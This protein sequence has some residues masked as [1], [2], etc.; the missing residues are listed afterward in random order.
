MNPLIPPISY[1]RILKISS[2]NSVVTF[3]LG[4]SGN[5][6]EYEFKAKFEYGFI[7]SLVVVIVSLNCKV[8]EISKS[9]KTPALILVITAF[10]F[11]SIP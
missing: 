10:E 4:Y 5:P 2:K 9:A 7:F 11:V 8:F 3:A 6:K 1:V